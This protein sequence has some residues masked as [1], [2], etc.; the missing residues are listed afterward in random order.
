[1]SPLLSDRQRLWVWERRLLAHLEGAGIPL[2]TGITLIALGTFAASWST[3][4]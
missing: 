4:P 1:M 3:T 2:L